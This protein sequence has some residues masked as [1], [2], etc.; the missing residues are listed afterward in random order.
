MTASRPSA[1]DDTALQRL[2]TEEV[3][4]LVGLTES[5]GRRAYAFLAIAD[6]ADLLLVTASSREMDAGTIHAIA[7]MMDTERARLAALAGDQ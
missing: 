7:A 1:I 4:A 2:C 5:G 6:G 3:R